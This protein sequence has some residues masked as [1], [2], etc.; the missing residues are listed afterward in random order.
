MALRH[1]PGQGWFLIGTREKK[2]GMQ[3]MSQTARILVLLERGF[4][5]DSARLV[6]LEHELAP[7]LQRIRALGTTENSGAVWKTD[8]NRGWECVESILRRNH[9]RLNHMDG[10]IQGSDK[11]A[12]QNALD[13]WQ[14]LQA[15]DTTLTDALVA[16][17]V[18][19]GDLNL[20]G[21]QEWN[22]MAHI[23]GSHLELIY[24]CVQALRIKL[25][26]LKQYSRTEVDLMVEG[27]LS[28]LPSHPR[29]EGVSEA[30][31]ARE[32][33]KAA[34]ELDIERHKCTGLADVVKG[35]LLWVD[36]TE[37]RVHRNLRL[38][39]E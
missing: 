30:E 7:L 11:A 1:A 37:E 31:Y 16:L 10:A 27:I 26:L 8:W 13:D 3:P 23:L 18:Q 36:T 14:S 2:N 22:G 29:E 9:N 21:R 5:T 28:K 38:K 25:E 17:R 32:Y 19:A 6:A 20:Q 4:R 15:E 12:L 33:D 39:V 35:M 24:A 34:A